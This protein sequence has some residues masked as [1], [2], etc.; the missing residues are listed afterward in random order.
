MAI[1]GGIGDMNAENVHDETVH[2]LGVLRNVLEYARIVRLLSPLA[3]TFNR[4]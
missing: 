3:K 2:I 4:P 1:T